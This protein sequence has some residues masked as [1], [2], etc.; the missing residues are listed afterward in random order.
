MMKVLK[1]TFRP[2]FINRVVDTIVFNSLE[3]EHLKEIVTLMIEQHKTRLAGQEIHHEV[4]EAAKEKIA[5][6]GYDQEYGARPLARSTQRHIEERLSE[7]L[8]SETELEGKA[9]TIDYKDDEFDISTDE[10]EKVEK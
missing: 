8:L 1:N 2:E 10:K 9:V 4:T 6:D 5:D 3:K 7:I